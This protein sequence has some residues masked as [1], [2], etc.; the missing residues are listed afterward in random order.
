MN[1]STQRDLGNDGLM[2]LNATSQDNVYIESSLGNNTPN[3]II[4]EEMVNVSHDDQYINYNNISKRT[5]TI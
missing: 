1:T 4:E 2:V 3:K 5:Q